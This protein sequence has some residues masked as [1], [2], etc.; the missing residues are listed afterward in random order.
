M[1]AGH[2]INDKKGVGTDRMTVQVGKKCGGVPGLE[3]RDREGMKGAG[4]SIFS[5][6]KI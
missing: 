6:L 2:C 4:G 3:G 1:L 5:E